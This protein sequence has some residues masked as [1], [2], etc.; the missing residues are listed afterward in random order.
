MYLGKF[1]ATLPAGHSSHYQ[2]E[3]TV[4]DPDLQIIFEEKEFFWPFGPQFGLKIGGGGGGA[5]APPPPRPPSPGSI[6]DKDIQ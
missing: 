1:E 4:P 3:Q 6:T 2:G 5:R